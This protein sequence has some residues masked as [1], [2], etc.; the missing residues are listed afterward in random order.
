MNDPVG[1]STGVVLCGGASR[2]MGTDKA[3][4][5]VAGRPMALLVADALRGAGV[6][7]VVALGEP[8]PKEL[9]ILPD[10]HRGGGPLAA[11]VGA[12][13][14]LGDLVVCP[15]DVP[16]ITSAGVAAILAGAMSSCAP[17]VLARS[18][19]PEPLIGFYRTE[20]LPVLRAAWETGERSVRGALASL[21][22]DH[23]GIGAHE[24]VNVNAPGDLEALSNSGVAAL[25]GR[26]AR[27][28]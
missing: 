16:Q 8:A 15:C 28:R 10:H 11:I 7:R 25:P 23:I 19:R 5:E 22:V 24:V 12:L 4:M 1:S 20:A 26:T 9:E 21:D 2:R 18:T 17:V 14:Q 13:E 6:G 27:D 3:T